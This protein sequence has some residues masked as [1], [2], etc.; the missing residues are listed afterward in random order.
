[1]HTVLPPVSNASLPNRYPTGVVTNS[2]VSDMDAKAK[3]TIRILVVDDEHTLRES[4]ASVLRLEGYSVTVCSRADEATNAFQKRAFD[5]VLLD[6]S[7]MLSTAAL[8]YDAN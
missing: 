4:C 5:I 2:D 1:M 6:R 8:R 3:A 7:R